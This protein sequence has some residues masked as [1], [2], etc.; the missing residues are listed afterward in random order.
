MSTQQHEAD[1]A[2]KVPDYLTGVQSWF[3]TRERTEIRVRHTHDN[4]NLAS[5][6]TTDPTT[7]PDIGL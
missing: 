1:K 6:I 7:I 4:G 5:P 3:S 2:S